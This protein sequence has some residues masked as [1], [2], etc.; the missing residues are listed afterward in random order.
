MIIIKKV[1]D[2]ERFL[3]VSSKVVYSLGYNNSFTE[4]TT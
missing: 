3:D 1:V 2:S 4:N